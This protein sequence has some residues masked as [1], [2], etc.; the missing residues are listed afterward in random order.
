M[1]F[2][3][4][5]YSTSI[6]STRLDLL[7]VDHV[8]HFQMDKVRNSDS[9]ISSTK[10]FH[11]IVLSI[12]CM[13]YRNFYSVKIKKLQLPC[14]SFMFAIDGQINTNQIAI[15]GSNSSRELIPSFLCAKE[16]APIHLNT[17][18]NLFV[19]KNLAIIFKATNRLGDL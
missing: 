8:E 9:R 10:I 4:M 1:S 14:I 2:K 13:V 19:I 6:S 15:R 12:S 18:L 5:F 3:E 17:F 16:N 11:E 7:N